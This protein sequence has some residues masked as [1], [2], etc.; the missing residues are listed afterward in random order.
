MPPIVKING[1]PGRDDWGQVFTWRM[2]SSALA[3]TKA[4]VANFG[5]VAESQV[6]SVLFIFSSST[7]RLQA[8][9]RSSFVG[10]DSPPKWVCGCL[11]CLP[12]SAEW[13]TV[14]QGNPTTQRTEAG[15]GLARD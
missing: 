9:Y 13:S 10:P 3:T 4:Q 6:G 5:A 8:L 15:R 7:P 11:S 12:L 14:F 2:T 1:A